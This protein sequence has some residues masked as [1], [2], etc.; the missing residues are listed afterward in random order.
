[1]LDEMR[2]LPRREWHAIADRRE[3]FHG[4]GSRA[5]RLTRDHLQ[6]FEEAT[7]KILSTTGV[8]VQNCVTTAA[9]RA[10][11]TADVTITGHRSDDG[12]AWRNS[13]LAA[14]AETAAAATLSTWLDPALFDLYME[15]W[16]SIRPEPEQTVR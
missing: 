1:M 16:R 2:R 8:W 14:A 3:L 13:A 12:P 7:L 6:P 10:R 4:T 5:P 9:F 15:P 11:Q